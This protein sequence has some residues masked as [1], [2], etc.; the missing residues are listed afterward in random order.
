MFFLP[1]GGG[2]NVVLKFVIG[3]IVIKAVVIKLTLEK[4]WYI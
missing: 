3:R 4:S 1:F 2:T